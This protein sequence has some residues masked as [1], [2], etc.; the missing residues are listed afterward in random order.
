[1]IQCFP[2]CQEVQPR[3]KNTW[4]HCHRMYVRTYIPQYWSAISLHTVIGIEVY[5]WGNGKYIYSVDMVTTG[6]IYAY[7]CDC[8]PYACTYDYIQWVYVGQLYMYVHLSPRLI[9]NYIYFAIIIKQFLKSNI[10]MNQ[11]Y[12]TMYMFDIPIVV[13]NNSSPKHAHL[14][15]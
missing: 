6:S 10:P 7:M 12:S 14:P 9:C 1:M 11:L 2:V 15:V 5:V 13:M 4:Y 8:M 3:T